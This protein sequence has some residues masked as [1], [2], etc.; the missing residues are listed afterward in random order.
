MHE[1]LWLLTPGVVAASLQLLPA[2]FTSQNQ[3]TVG[4]SL[5]S[6][7]TTVYIIESLASQRDTGGL[8]LIPPS[9]LEF[10]RVFVEDLEEA[11]E[12]SWAL[13]VVGVPPTNVTGIVLDLFQ[14]DSSSL[15]YENGSPT[16]E[17]YVLEIGGNRAV[18]SGTGARGMWWGTRTLLQQLILSSWTTL[19]ASRISDAPAYAT[20]GFMLDAGRKWYSPSFLKELCTYASFFK[21]SEFHYH[22]SD[23][24]PLN[25]GH[26]DTWNEVY[27][28]FS[29]RPESE[30]LQGLI[31]RQNETLTRSDSEDLQQHCASRGITVVPE[32]EAPGHCLSI[33]KWKPELALEKKDLLNLTHPDSIPTVKS[34]WEEFLPWFQSKEVHIGADEYD[35]TL[36][37]D[38]ISFV[39][40]LSAFINTTSQKRT[41]IWGT[42]EPSSTQTIDPSVIVQH[43]QYGQSDPIELYDEGYDLINTEDWW[44]YMSLKN[45]HT[46]ILPAPYPQSFNETR[47]L[48]FAGRDGWQWHPAL[49]N[50]V[51]TTMQLPAGAK[52][53][54]GAILAA[55]NDNGPDAS[56]QLEAYYAMRRGIPLVAARAWSGARGPG[57]EMGSVDDA[58]DFLSARA[59]GQN[60]DRKIALRAGASGSTDGNK[61][62]EPLI[63]WTRPGNS[64]SRG[65]EEVV[66]LGYGSKGM[67]YT[68]ELEVTGPFTLASEDVVLRMAGDG[69]LK[70]VA[71]GWE[72]PLREVAEGDGFDAGH[73]GR[74][75]ANATS[76]THNPVA[77]ATPATVTI[78]GDVIGGSRVYVNGTFAGR[79][80]VFVFG[81]K[82]TVFSWS[83]MAFVAPL[84]TLSGGGG[85][86]VEKLVL[87]DGV[88]VPGSGQGSMNGTGDGNGNGGGGTMPVT[89]GAVPRYSRDRGR[90]LFGVMLVVVF[91]LDWVI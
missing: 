12:Q 49:F 57:L 64:S 66:R 47:V 6:V 30:E 90:H 46:P 19:P 75:W 9:G 74:I 62:G 29:L 60:L 34:I 10:A 26:N 5:N 38:Y 67:N 16:E 3:T 28:Q 14:G 71:D 13:Q 36:A 8:T 35:S 85:G 89:G 73:P 53:N 58:V 32:I 76:S 84:D 59:P 15:S 77:L 25:R 31:Q 21:M 51:N 91:G 37:N 70:F 86:G 24:Y 45:D 79:F 40:E 88:R 7:S 83:Q 82:N 22:T 80:E 65:P 11:S 69:I 55:W 33:T 68:L 18:I 44:A 54:K 78:T 50:P 63:S 87:W 56:T 20:R 4:F 2:P 42:Y 48:N 72:Y 81:G 1:W 27:S 43:W 61:G 52:G 41:R 39:N 23:N 17:G